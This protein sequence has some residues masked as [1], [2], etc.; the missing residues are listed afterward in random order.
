[1]NSSS[2]NAPG[3]T[4]SDS[5]TTGSH[6]PSL[7]SHQAA[8]SSSTALIPAPGL[9]IPVSGG[10]PYPLSAVY[11]R[12]IK[13]ELIATSPQ[14]YGRGVAT[15][16]L[17]A[18]LLGAA[19]RAQE[20]C[21]LHV[22]GGDDNVPARRLYERFC[23]APVP[24]DA[25]HR[26]NKDVWALVDIAGALRRVAEDGVVAGAAVVPTVTGADGAA[27]VEGGIKHQASSAT[28]EAQR[29]QHEKQ[30]MKDV[31]SGNAIIMHVSIFGE[32]HTQGTN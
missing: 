25:F 31:K 5:H 8:L 11:M 12:W 29:E 7:Q 15:L 22:A 24:G 18:V 14:H 30:Q 20:R 27:P 4:G 3:A 6:S 2:L 10:P 32:G 1:M 26:P 21:V 16:L 23:F 17:S 19:L 9:A 13:L 28:Q